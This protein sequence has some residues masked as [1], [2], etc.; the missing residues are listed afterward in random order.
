MELWELVNINVGD[1]A[2]SSQKG[3][4]QLTVTIAIYLLHGLAEG[5]NKSCDKYPVIF[6]WQDIVLSVLWAPTYDD[7]GLAARQK[8]HTLYSP[9]F[10]SGPSHQPPPHAPRTTRQFS[11]VVL[12]K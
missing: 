9:P 12:E 7:I 3:S 6:K 5:K 1:F 4:Q 8:T 2:K 11:H 10:K